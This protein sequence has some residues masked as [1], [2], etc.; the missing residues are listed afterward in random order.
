MHVGVYP[1]ARAHIPAHRTV[2]IPGYLLRRN[3]GC[4]PSNSISLRQSMLYRARDA[5]SFEIHV[6]SLGGY[7]AT[8]WTLLE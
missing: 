7:T 5:P 1:Y 2:S 3:I 8:L 6:I 4:F